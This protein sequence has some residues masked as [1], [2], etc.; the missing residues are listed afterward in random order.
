MADGSRNNPADV[1]RTSRTSLQF[2]CNPL[3]TTFHIQYRSIQTKVST[4]P[5]TTTQ[6]LL[7]KARGVCRGAAAL[8]PLCGFPFSS[9]KILHALRQKSK[10]H[11]VFKKSIS[12]LLL[13]YLTTRTLY[14]PSI[15]LSSSNALADAALSRSIRV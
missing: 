4:V 8:R 11:T 2:H 3:G 12:N 7:K 15:S 5:H 1:H 14:I 9:K 6:E 10:R 13:L